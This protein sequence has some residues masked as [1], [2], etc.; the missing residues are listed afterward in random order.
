MRS[1]GPRWPRAKFVLVI[2]IAVL[3]DNSASETE[4]VDGGGVLMGGSDAD[5]SDGGSITGKSLGTASVGWDTSG[6][7][8]DVT[9][10]SAQSSRMIGRCAVGLIGGPISG[11]GSGMV[12]SSSVGM[13]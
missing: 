11:G 7:G 10:T 13:K 5:D 1:L 2:G 9:D 12:E 6:G 8:K 4:S 3:V